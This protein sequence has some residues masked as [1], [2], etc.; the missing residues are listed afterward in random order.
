MANG[1]VA[2]EG[3][4]LLGPQDVVVVAT[5]LVTTSRNSGTGPMVQLWILLKDEHPV[6]A[7]RN[8]NDASICGSCVFRAQAP[9]GKSRACYV[10]PMGP[11]IV[12]REYKAGSYGRVLSASKGRAKLKA[13]GLPVRVGAYGDPAAVPIEFWRKILDGL[14]VTAYTSAWR[15]HT[16]LQEFAMASVRSEDEY[17]EATRRGW[18]TYRARLESD[19]LLPG[20]FIC[21]KTEE[22]GEKATCFSCLLCDGARSRAKN[23]VTIIHGTYGM[24]AAAKQVLVGLRHNGRSIAA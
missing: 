24:V 18:R 15:H 4:S 12:Y 7:I 11:A 8:G 22:G 5:G 19:P 23:P 2:Y 20:E 3:R 13:S 9:D 17:F 16:E 14:R 21:P 1:F 10:N 6:E